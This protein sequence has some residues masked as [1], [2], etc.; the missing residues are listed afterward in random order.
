MDYGPFGIP[1]GGNESSLPPNL[2]EAAIPHDTSQGRLT[3]TSGTPVTTADVTT[4]TTIY[5]TPYLGNRIALFDGY[6]WMLA[7]FAELSI[8]LGTL[9]SGA[10]YDVFAY[11]DGSVVKLEFGPA[12]S[13]DTAR[14]TLGAISL[15]DGVYV[16]TANPTRRYLGTFRTTAAT[17]TEDGARRRFLWNMYNRVPRHLQRLE[18]ANTW[19]YATATYRQANASATNQIEIVVGLAETTIQME[20]V[21]QHYCGTANT[22]TAI[23]IGTDSTTAYTAGT[24]GMGGITPPVT[25]GRMNTTRVV[26][27]TT[28]ALGYH[29]YAW[30]E[31]C[32]S[33]VTVTFY[34]QGPAATRIQSGI[35][36][37]ASI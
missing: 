23:A 19:T 36:G 10:N 18:S 9:T 24:L 17:T 12:W 21:S 30:L 22:E 37:V 35:A 31:Q 16:L 1:K 20:V 34:G 27:I 5:F 2:A 28:V 26:L 13:S 32:P 8:P 6:R 4:A 33:A 7:L 25:D 14:A 29:Y 3:L 11:W 15:K